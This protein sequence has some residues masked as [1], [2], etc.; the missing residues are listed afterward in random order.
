MVKTKGVDMALGD[1]IISHPSPYLPYLALILRRGRQQRW[2]IRQSWKGGATAL[3]AGAIAIKTTERQ[4]HSP[5]AWVCLREL[6]ERRREK[7]CANTPEYRNLE[8]LKLCK[9][10]L[11]ME[12]IGRGRFERGKWVSPVGSATAGPVE[13]FA[14]QG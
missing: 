4:K 1:L 11:S 2:V 13:Q 8:T 9:I 12:W 6:T 3:P 5:R 7:R 14:T 10:L